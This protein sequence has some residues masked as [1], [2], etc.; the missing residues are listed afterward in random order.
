MLA[1]VPPSVWAAKVS[2][3]RLPTTLYAV[4]GLLPIAICLRQDMVLAGVL[5]T[6][7]MGIPLWAALRNAPAPLTSLGPTP[8]TPLGQVA[9]S[10]N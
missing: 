6:I 5:G 10:G 8:S 2:P 7:A 9:V 3:H 4:N 1:L